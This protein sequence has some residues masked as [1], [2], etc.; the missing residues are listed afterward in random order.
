VP[1]TLAAMPAKMSDDETPTRADAEKPLG[2]EP[3]PRF[4]HQTLWVVLMWIAIVLL[5]VLMG[6]YPDTVG[7][8]LTPLRRH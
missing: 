2:V 6:L 1:C 3:E 7:F 4:V 8:W 5:I